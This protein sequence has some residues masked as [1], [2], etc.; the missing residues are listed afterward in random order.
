MTQ[1]GGLGK[2]SLTK[3]S[4]PISLAKH[5]QGTGSGR[6]TI[7]L[8]WDASGGSHGFFHKKKES[9]DLDLGCLYELT[10]GR[11]SAV[12]ALG[13][14]FGNY[15]GPPWIK[16][17]K[18]DRS[19]TST[20]GE[21]LFLNAAHAADVKRLLIYTFIYEGAPSWA[22]A[23]PVVTVRQEAG[24]AIEVVL[25]ETDPEKTMCAIALIENRGGGDL[26]VSRQLRY[27]GG[28]AEMDQAFGW[29]LRWVHGSKD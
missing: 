19:G 2:V 25:D 21:N 8:N 12:Q 14:S 17:D 22:Q 10:D 13:G 4:G 28:H 6:I 7:N 18:D 9:I 24:P 23:K 1:G 27:F 16:L 29:G 5:G 20:D 26:E 3:G 15:D 11:K